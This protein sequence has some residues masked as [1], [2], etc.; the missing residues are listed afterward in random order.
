[1][2]Y[3][4]T[5]EEQDNEDDLRDIEFNEDD[6]PGAFPNDLTHEI[7][8]EEADILEIK[9]LYESFTSENDSIENVNI[10]EALSNPFSFL[11]KYKY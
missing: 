10:S 8:N 9:K 4:L 6:L 7:F 2:N 11:E 5:D 1:M 3:V